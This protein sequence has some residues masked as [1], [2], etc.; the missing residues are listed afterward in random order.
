MS[1]CHEVAVEVEEISGISFFP[2]YE[3]KSD[4]YNIKFHTLATLVPGRKLLQV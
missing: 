1:L 2:E 4:S 3:V